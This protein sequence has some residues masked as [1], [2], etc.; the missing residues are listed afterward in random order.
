MNIVEMYEAIKEIAL[1]T[2]MINDVVLIKSDDNIDELIKVAKYRTMFIV[3]Q[4][5]SLGTDD[6]D[7]NMSIS[8]VDKTK[9]TDAIYLHSVNDGLS[10]LRIVSDG[11]NHHHNQRIRYSEILIGSGYLNNGLL[12]T[13]NTD[14]SFEFETVQMPN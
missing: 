6:N 1:A 14:V 7:I 5:A 13:L 8:I 9:E 2:K 12:T 11:M 4:T 3:V 10:V